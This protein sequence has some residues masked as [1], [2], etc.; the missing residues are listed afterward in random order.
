MSENL[1]ICFDRLTFDPD[2]EIFH[3][4]IRGMPGERLKIKPCPIPRKMKVRMF[5][6]A[7]VLET[8]SDGYGEYLTYVS[9]KQLKRLS[10]PQNASQ[11]NKAIK[12]LIDALPD[13]LIFFLYWH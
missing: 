4:I 13:E 9:V 2:D 3:Q 12:A 5:D 7:R 1:V 11:K 10:I 8:D 6:G